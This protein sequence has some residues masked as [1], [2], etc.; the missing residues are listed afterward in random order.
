MS[1][2][3]ALHIQKRVQPL[4]VHLIASVFLSFGLQS[5]CHRSRLTLHSQTGKI[6]ATILQDYLEDK[7]RWQYARPLLHDRSSTGRCSSSNSHHH[8]VSGGEPGTCRKS[9]LCLLAPRC[10]SNSFA[11]FKK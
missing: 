5:N 7:M 11:N 2:S 1:R 4:E 6:V 9:L 8:L 3:G 10:I